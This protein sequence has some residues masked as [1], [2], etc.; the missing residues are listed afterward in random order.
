MD[1]IL[2]FIIVLLFTPVVRQ[3]A[4]ASG[5]IDDVDGDPL[6]IHKEPVAL[7]GGVTILSGMAIG[8]FIHQKLLIDFSWELLGIAAA[9]L[10]VFGVGLVDDIKGVRP[11]V[12]LLMEF[13]AASVIIFAGIKVNI[14]PHQWV[15]VLLTLFYMTGAINALNVTDGMDGLCVG[16]SLVSCG[17]FFFLGSISGN[18]VLMILSAILFM[19]SLGF[20]PY[21]FHPAK[22]FLGDAGSRFIGF[23]L[24]A[25]A[26]MATSKPYNIA[27]FIAPILIVGIPVFDMAFAI[28][29]RLKHRRPLF[30]GDRNHLYD[31]LLKK[32]WS[33][34]RVWIVMC[35]MQVIFVGI[36]L[37]VYRNL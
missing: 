27:N 13:I 37:L 1:Y 34:L 8:I 22:I 23:M 5:I 20:L 12:R 21:N 18:T 33:Q 10:L 29:R 19:S 3:M 35:G 26:V 36:A 11:R 4:V 17:G 14:I 2:S 6:K 31:L 16:V 7:L 15:A 24:G 30:V 25:M 28:L 9:G 32:G